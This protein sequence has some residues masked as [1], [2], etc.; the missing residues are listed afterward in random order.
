MRV[1]RLDFAPLPMRSTWTS[2]SSLPRRAADSARP[3][4]PRRRRA[5]RA[6]Q[7]RSR[8]AGIANRFIR[9]VSSRFRAALSALA[10]R[11]SGDPALRFFRCTSSSEIA[12]GVMPEIR[13]AWPMS[14]GP[15]AA[16]L[17]A[18]LVGQA[19][20]AR[21]SRGRPAARSR[22]GGVAARS[23]R[24]ARDVARVVRLDLE[25]ADPLLGGLRRRR[26]RARPSRRRAR[27]P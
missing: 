25:A 4:A 16:E 24:L 8:R 10:G 5:P 1:E 15:D 12:A 3:P 22:R 13:A 20:H 6:R 9:R 7:A 21:R 11:A 2:A 27:A 14:C 23:R 26:P 17:L 18:D 19:V